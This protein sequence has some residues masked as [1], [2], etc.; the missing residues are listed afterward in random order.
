MYQQA[1]Q[2]QA[3]MHATSTNQQVSPTAAAAGCATMI[4]QQAV[5]LL[6]FG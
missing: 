2:Q 4:C 5:Q 3:A 6:H 1:L